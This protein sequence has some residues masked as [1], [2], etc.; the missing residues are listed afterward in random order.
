MHLEPNPCHR[1]ECRD[2]A[3]QNFMDCR[4]ALVM[5]DTGVGCDSCQEA[6]LCRH[7]NDDVLAR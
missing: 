3:I 2:V 5:T 1:K 4:A 7:H 6:Q